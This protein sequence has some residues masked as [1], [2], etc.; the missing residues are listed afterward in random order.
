MTYCYISIWDHLYDLDDRR[1][2]LKPSPKDTIRIGKETLLQ[3]HHH[4]LRAFETRL[5]QSANVL[6]VAKIK[7]CIH[8][9]QNV[10]GGRLE[11]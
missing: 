6:R 7:S 9:V 1:T 4:K 2:I 3:T 10:H 11:L 8:L 5:D